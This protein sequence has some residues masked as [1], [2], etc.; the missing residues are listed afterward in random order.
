MPSTD[1]GESTGGYVGVPVIV[2]ATVG[3]PR[4]KVGIGVK[5]AAVAL[6]CAFCVVISIRYEN[7]ASKKLSRSTPTNSIKELVF[8]FFSG[9]TFFKNTPLF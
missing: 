8:T 7:A 1:A 3:V 9:F 4:E 6:A 2:P 5:L